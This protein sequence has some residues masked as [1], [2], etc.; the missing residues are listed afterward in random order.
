MQTATPT[1][2]E[3]SDA[4]DIRTRFGI[5]KSTLY[6]LA[7]EGKI[8]TSSLRERGKLRGKRLF[9]LDSIA[10]FIEAR[11]TGGEEVGTPAEP[12]A[13]VAPD[14]SKI[15]VATGES[16]GQSISSRKGKDK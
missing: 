11:A 6:R 1:R 2:P 7:D 13:G 5:S 15:R 8:R 16:P 9:S 4:K 14:F 3:W 10:A 12:I